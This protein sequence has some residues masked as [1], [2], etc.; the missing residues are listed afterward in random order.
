MHALTQAIQLII[1]AMQL[2]GP[3]TKI[4]SGN[5]IETLSTG[6][7]VWF[8]L[9]QL[10]RISVAIMLGYG[11]PFPSLLV[12]D[13]TLACAHTCACTRRRSKSSTY[14]WSRESTA[15]YSCPCF[16][17]VRFMCVQL[18]SHVCMRSWATGTSACTC[19]NIDEYVAI[20]ASVNA[21]RPS[22]TRLHLH[23]QFAGKRMVS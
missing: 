2:R 7:T 1:A 10:S 19:R 3:T 17:S 9:V 22:T 20:C 21:P 8:V 11:A 6:R 5:H 16:H 23:L 14:G 18:H 15:H 12:L 4:G 13:C